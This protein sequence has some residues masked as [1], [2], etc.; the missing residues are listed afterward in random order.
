V[1]VKTHPISKHVYP[2]GVMASYKRAAN[3]P[4]EAADDKDRGATVRQP[5][6]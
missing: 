6:K 3:R 2:T 4:E 1:V 5:T